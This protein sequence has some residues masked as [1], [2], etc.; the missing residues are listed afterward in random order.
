MAVLKRGSV[1]GSVERNGAKDVGHGKNELMQAG[2]KRILP[3][4]GVFVTTAVGTFAQHI[5]SPCRRSSP[6]I[7]GPFLLLLLTLA[8]SPPY[9]IGWVHNIDNAPAKSDARSVIGLAAA[10]STIAILFTILRLSVR[11]KTVGRFGLD[12]AAIAAST[13]CMH[14]S[15]EMLL[16]VRRCPD[17]FAASR[18]RVQCYIHLS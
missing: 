8:M 3:G 17:N 13:V 12:D 9:T 10:F 2:W 15:R 14:A 7:A 18:C 11:W 6:S 16:G 4:Q 1:V 5:Q